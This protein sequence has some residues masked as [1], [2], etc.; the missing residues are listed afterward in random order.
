MI[1][2]LI[3]KVLRAIVCVHAGIGGAGPSGIAM[4]MMPSRLS[5]NFPLL[6]TIAAA[7][8]MPVLPSITHTAANSATPTGGMAHTQAAS[9]GPL[10][11]VL[12]G[13]FLGEGLVPLPAKLVFC[14][15]NLEFVDMCELVPEAW[16]LTEGSEAET[17]GLAKA[18]SFFPRQSPGVHGIPGADC[19]V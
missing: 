8:N 9:A 11:T 15:T 7:Q 12:A 18:V 5:A 2:A 10:V 1:A 14:I 16:L 6:L 13:M 17:S 19:E 3:L 4:G